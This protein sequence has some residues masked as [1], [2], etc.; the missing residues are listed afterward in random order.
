M[1]MGANPLLSSTFKQRDRWSRLIARDPRVKLM[2]CHVLRSF[3]LCAHTDKDGRL[4]IDPTYPELAKTADCHRATAIRAVAVAEEIGIVRKARHSDGRVS[5]AY[6][7][8]LPEAGSNGRKFPPAEVATDANV[9]FP[10]VADLP[11]AAGS[12]RRTAATVLSVESKDE[13]YTLHSGESVFISNS[14]TSDEETA[15]RGADIRARR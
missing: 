1:P 12:N 7:L 15:V 8:L 4:V 5:N 11:V 6:E 2:H 3:A 14:S 13:I 10:T 9:N